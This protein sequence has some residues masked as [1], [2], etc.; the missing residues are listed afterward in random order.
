MLGGP[1]RGTGVATDRGARWLRSEL[2]TGCTRLATRNDDVHQA[3]SQDRSP[4]SGSQTAIS[5]RAL[6]RLCQAPL[7]VGRKSCSGV[8]QAG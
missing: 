3:A 6:R 8:R 2:R 1:V 4:H 5:P 7:S